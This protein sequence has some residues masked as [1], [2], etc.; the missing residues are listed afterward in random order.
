MISN[1]NSVISE[2]KTITYETKEKEIV[3]IVIDCANNALSKSNSVELTNEYIRK[4]Y[5]DEI[6]LVKEKLE[7]MEEIE[8]DDFEDKVIRGVTDEEAWDFLLDFFS[9]AK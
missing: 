1:L 5:A 4:T 8:K 7:A 9:L 3:D 2:L 6:S